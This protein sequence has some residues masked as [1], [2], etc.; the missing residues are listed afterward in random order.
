M[1]GVWPPVKPHQL[2]V[3][4]AHCAGGRPSGWALRAGKH[5]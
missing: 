4:T 2:D 3:G 1:V 5:L